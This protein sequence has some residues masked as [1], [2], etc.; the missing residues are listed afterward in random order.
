M[1]KPKVDKDAEHQEIPYIA[2]EIQNGT[3]IFENSF[4]FLIKSNI[5]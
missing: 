4:Q 3:A 5:S 2:W 1:D